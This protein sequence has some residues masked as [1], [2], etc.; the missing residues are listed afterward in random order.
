MA[1]RRL[2]A[3]LIVVLVVSTVAATL[4]A[5]TQRNSETTTTAESPSPRAAQ[6]PGRSGRLIE[7]TVQTSSK[8]PPTLQLLLGDQLELTVRVGA[9]LQ[10]EIPAL[11]MLEDA[12]PGAPAHFSILTASPGRYGVR[13]LGGRPIAT[14]RVTEPAGA[15]AGGGSGDPAGGI[16]RNDH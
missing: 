7:K 14:I 10:V 9:P 5:P 1:A 2:I 3:L 16:R 13:A 6:E 4:F 12:D 11:G 15:K 8:R